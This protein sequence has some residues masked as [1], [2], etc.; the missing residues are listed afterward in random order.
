MKEVVE[1]LQIAA[2][3]WKPERVLEWAFDTFGETVAISSAFGAEGMVLIDIVSRV[4]QNFRIFTLDTE[5]LFPETYNLM[6]QVEQR[7]GITIE[8]VY[9][10]LSPE[11]QE[12]VH[13]TALWQRDPDQ[14]CNLRKVEPLRRKL[15][16][17]RAWITSIRRD[18]TA[19]RAS[20]GKVEWDEKFGLVKINPIADWSSKQVWQYIRQHDVPHNILHER[21]YPSIGCTHCTR[22]VR[23]GENPRAGR[24]AGSSKTECGLHIIQ[25]AAQ[26]AGGEV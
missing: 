16:E 17:L 15:G 21:N 1:K 20:A 8:K 22:A 13:G 4:R 23:P 25:A 24:W 18:Q 2:E 9:P 10:L 26:S 14:C 7:Y 3:S 6:D 12:R 5:F 19:A 11:E